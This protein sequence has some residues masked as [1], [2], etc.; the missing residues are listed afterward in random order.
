MRTG[1]SAAV[2]VISSAGAAKLE[3]G[4]LY[5]FAD[6]EGFQQYFKGIPLSGLNFPPHDD[7][8]Q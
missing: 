6:V 3:T 2:P 4:I 1:V 8:E 7:F 5:D